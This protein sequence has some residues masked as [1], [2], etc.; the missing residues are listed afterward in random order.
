MSEYP[1][2]V[3]SSISSRVVAELGA[4]TVVVGLAAILVGGF[5]S[6]AVFV[7]TS[8]IFVAT[9][10]VAWPIAQPILKFFLRVASSM[11]EKVWDKILD[12]FM[13]GGFLSKI[14]E[15]CTLAGLA[16]SART[17]IVTLPIVVGMVLLVRFTLSR[18]PKNFRKWVGDVTK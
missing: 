5:L 7:V 14:R 3:A 8:F 10:Y 2:P 9:V 18:K 6:A 15:L 16:S 11:L 4:V 12:F 1:H 13:D 17:L